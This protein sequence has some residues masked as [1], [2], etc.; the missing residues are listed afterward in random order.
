MINKSKTDEVITSDKRGDRMGDEVI[1]EWDEDLVTTPQITPFYAAD[2][3]IINN[4][5]RIIRN[6][7][8]ELQLVHAALDPDEI[9]TEEQHELYL[10]CWPR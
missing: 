2:Q 7:G 4:M 10:R 1:I 8:N 3:A 5:A 6:L 9:L